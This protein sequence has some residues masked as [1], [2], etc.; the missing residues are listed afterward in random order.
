MQVVLIT[1]SNSPMQQGV[2]YGMLVGWVVV[3]AIV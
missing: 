2:K 1:H 3:A